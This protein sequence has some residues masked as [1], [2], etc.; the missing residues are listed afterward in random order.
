MRDLLLLLVI[1]GSL[2]VALRYP[3]A[4]VLLW[5]WFTLASPQ[6]AAYTLSAYSLNTVIAIATLAVLALHGE[7]WRIKW[8]V[9]PLLLIAFAAWIGISQHFSL[10]PDWSM[11][12]TDRFSKILLFVFL[13]AVTVTDRLRFQALLWMLVIV[14][15]FFGLKGGLFTLM[16]FG[17]DLYWGLERT[18]L[19]DN[20]HIAIAMATSL[21]LLLYMADQTRHRIVRYVLLG[22]TVMTVIGIIGTHSRGGF[23]SL[24]AFGG[25]YWLGSRRKILVG[26]LGALALLAALPT[27]PTDWTDRMATIAEADEDASFRARLE[28]WEINWLLARENPLTGAGLRVPY[29][30][31]AARLVSEHQPRAAHSVYFEVLGG[32]GFVGLA[33]YLGIFGYG[34]L[35]AHRLAR[36]KDEARKWM[37][38]YGLAARNAL[39]VFAVGGASVSM[40]MW[41]GY[42][43][44]IALVSAV[45]QMK[46]ADAD[47]APAVRKGIF[48][49]R[50][51]TA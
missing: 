39:L 34:I 31:E 43:I 1:S 24:L 16:T 12:Y 23:L 51:V 40:E 7:L 22:V 13:C 32:T 46:T 15:G 19:Y 4:A 10:M 50:A 38:A 29:T 45:T 36:A 25:L 21:P 26:A 28:A 35:S 30:D 2:L 20:N 8:R 3:F 6:Q 11:P 14:M 48:A 17:Q 37:S 42:L 41:E 9:L 18:I 49:D 5:A 27:L 33:L 47:A 44:V